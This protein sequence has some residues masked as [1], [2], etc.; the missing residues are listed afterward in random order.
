VSRADVV[1]NY[2]AI[3]STRLFLCQCLVGSSTA[4]H[5]VRLQFLAFQNMCTATRSAIPED[6]YGYAP[7]HSIRDVR[8]RFSPTIELNGNGECAFLVTI[9]SVYNNSERGHGK[10]R[11]RFLRLISKDYAIWQRSYYHEVVIRSSGL[12]SIS[13]RIRISTNSRPAWSSSAP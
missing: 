8:L 10:M 4:T 13:R 2:T 7:H 1:H 3:F 6:G 5:S 11:H 12:C 9:N